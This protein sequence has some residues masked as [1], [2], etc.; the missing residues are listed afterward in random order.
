M[1]AP[2]SHETRLAQSLQELRHTPAPQYLP[3]GPGESDGYRAWVGH[4]STSLLEGRLPSEP[5]PAGFVGRVLDRGRLWLLAEVAGKNRGAGALALRV[6]AEAPIIVEVP[7]SFFDEGTLP[8]GIT[9]FEELGARALLVNTVHR[10]GV[11]P[12]DERMERARSGTSESDVAHQTQSFFHQ[13]HLE[14]GRIW[15]KAHVVQLHGFRDEK[16]PTAKI[17]ISASGTSASTAPLAKA[18]NDA[19]GVGTARLFPEEVDQLGGTQNA[20]AQANRDESRA[21]VHIEMAASLRTQM[22]RQKSLQ[23]RFARA[24][25]KGLSVE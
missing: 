24:L 19:F 20:Q 9:V 12:D 18:L 2:L 7:H 17:V 6:A 10:G 11:G 4:L 13:A 16:V 23:E 14:L 15:P 21:F 1:P 25:S 5:P 3:P 22:V 8:I